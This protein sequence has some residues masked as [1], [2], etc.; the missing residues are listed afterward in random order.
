MFLGIFGATMVAITL[1][2]IPAQFWDKLAEPLARKLAARLSFLR[3][4]RLASA[5][6]YV[7]AWGEK[8]IADRAARRGIFPRWL[9]LSARISAIITINVLVF[10]LACCTVAWNLHNVDA[11]KW[12]I[13]MRT[14]ELV[15][16]V[17]LD[18]T[19][20]MFAPQP[21][22]I[23]GWFIV[24][25]TTRDG[26]TINLIDGSSPVSFD[27]PA[28]V[29]QSYKSQLWMSYLISFWWPDRCSSPE[30]FASYIGTRWN[31]EHPNR[32]DQFSTVDIYMMTEYVDTD[33]DGNPVKSGNV[34][35]ELVWE[36][37]FY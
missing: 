36:E 20:N 4:S 12:P 28:S 19:W 27:R 18:Q 31:R 33:G 23:D 32:D 30:L 5:Y 6:A 1:A 22:T 16:S 2:F 21:H 17:G 8:R 3:I 24:E 25:G 13:S 7:V 11:V 29:C 10:Y 34:A 9:T 37:W 14:R 15:P 35:Q 26:K